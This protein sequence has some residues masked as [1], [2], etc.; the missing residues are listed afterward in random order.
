MGQ[1]RRFG[2]VIVVSCLLVGTPLASSAQSG[3]GGRCAER[4]PESTF[5]TSAS[6]GPVDV[7]GSG[8]GEALADRYAREWGELAALVQDEMGGLDDGV[9][10]CVFEDTLPLDATALGWPEGQALRA[11]AFGDERLVVISS[12]LIAEAPDAGRNGVLHVAQYQVSDGSYPQPFADDVKGWYRNRID[13]TVEVVHNAFVRQNTGLAEPWPPFPWTT[14][15]MVDPLV[16]NPEFGYGGA[17][18]FTNYAV[19]TAGSG[20]LSDPS[21][22][23]LGELDDGWRQALFDESG[24]IPGGSKGWIVGL[25]GAIALVA[26]GVGLAMW[27]RRQRRRFEAQLRD[28]D[29]LEEKAREARAAEAVRTSVATR[30]SGRDSRVGRGRHRSARVTDDDRDRT[31]AGGAVRTG[32]DGV[33]PRGE[34]GDDRF[35][36]PEFD[37]DD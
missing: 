29:F 34:S 8:I 25:V 5:E 14:A 27:D 11:A 17:G 24:A 22:S 6:N 12:W 3:T 2:A 31:P 36:H 26:L 30:S 21:E 4:F 32:D 1:V 37:G 23:E 35:R 33:A 18:D 28:L 19:A 20:V 9:T 7:H 13:R 15:Q 10:V 16:W